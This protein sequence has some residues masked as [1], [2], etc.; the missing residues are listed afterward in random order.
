MMLHHAA[1]T[2]SSIK[3]DKWVILFSSQKA[4]LQLI[5]LF[6]LVL[7]S[8]NLIITSVDVNQYKRVAESWPP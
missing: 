7:I 6:L 8:T 3:S 5:Q 4:I 1:T 2:L